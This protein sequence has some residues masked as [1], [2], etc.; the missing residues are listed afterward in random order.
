M[1][2]RIVDGVSYSTIAGAYA[3]VQSDEWIILRIN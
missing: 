1:A 2:D 3:D